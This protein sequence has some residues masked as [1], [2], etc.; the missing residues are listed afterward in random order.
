NPRTESTAPAGRSP[1]HL[2]RDGLARSDL[3]TGLRALPQYD[4]GGDAGIRIRGDD[5]DAESAVAQD[6][7]R[8]IAVDADQIGH[9][10]GDA[11]LAAVDQE[12]DARSR[13][14]GRRLLRHDDVRRVVLRSDLGDAGQLESVLREPQLR[15]AL[16]LAHEQRYLGG[17][18]TG[19]QPH[20]DAA[21]PPRDRAR[22]WILREDAAGGHLRI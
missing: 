7:R 9:H 8:T 14:G 2:E 5:G 20:L 11:A 4:A 16:G 1:A 3:K 10:V 17:V 13:A 15:R 18:L 6:V 21:L 19:A 12:R 22:R